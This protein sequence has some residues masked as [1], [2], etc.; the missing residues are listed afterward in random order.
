V[1]SNAREVSAGGAAGPETPRPTQPGRAW[2][3]RA[4][5]MLPLL[6][7]LALLAAATLRH[8][9]TLAIGAALAHGETPAVPDL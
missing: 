9:Q 3:A 8:H 6:A 1:T 7:V 4:G 2:R 5:L